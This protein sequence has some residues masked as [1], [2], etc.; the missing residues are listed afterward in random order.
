MQGTGAPEIPEAYAHVSDPFVVLSMAAAATSK[1]RIGTGICIVAA[2]HPVITAHQVATLDWFSGGRF[3]FGVG[4]GWLKEELEIL[5]ADYATRL[6]QA[7]EHVEVMRTLWREPD[8]G[9][10]GKWI[11]LPPVHLNP[12]HIRQVGLR[13]S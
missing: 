4:A 12:R 1:L 6:D 2:R 7:R 3:L 13:S 9:F 11:S 10:V 5:G 8:H